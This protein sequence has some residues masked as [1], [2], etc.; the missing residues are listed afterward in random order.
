[1]PQRITTDDLEK[2]LRGGK[3]FPAYA[4]VGEEYYLLDLARNL[5]K[6]RICGD[7]ASGLSCINFSGRA[8]TNSPQPPT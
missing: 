4:A 8:V 2:S 1:M 5:L 7:D 3:L 6:E